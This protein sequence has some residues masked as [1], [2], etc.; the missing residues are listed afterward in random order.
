MSLNLSGHRDVTSIFSLANCS[1]SNRLKT[2]F[3]EGQERAEAVEAHL[4]T[5]DGAEKEKVDE[6]IKEKQFK[7]NKDG[8]PLTDAQKRKRYYK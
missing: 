8:K 7:A 5:L 2:H 3:L 6:F 4:D 1:C